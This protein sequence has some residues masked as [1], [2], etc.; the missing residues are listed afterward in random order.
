M[1]AF[2]IEFCSISK[3]ADEPFDPSYERQ[4]SLTAVV[5]CRRRRDAFNAEVA[6]R[7]QA[8]RRPQGLRALSA[9]V[10]EHNRST[11]LVRV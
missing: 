11:A 10:A 6:R 4:R 8:K 5:A 7:E 3:R 2:N 1:T 9:I